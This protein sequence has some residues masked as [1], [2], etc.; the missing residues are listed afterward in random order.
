MRMVLMLCFEWLQSL[1]DTVNIPHLISWIFA[2]GVKFYIYCLPRGV[3]SFIFMT[4][5]SFFSVTSS[6]PTRV[7]FLSEFGILS[8]C[9]SNIIISFYVSYVYIFNKYIMWNAYLILTKNVF[10]E[11]ISLLVRRLYEWLSPAVSH[12]DQRCKLFLRRGVFS[13]LANSMFTRTTPIN[14]R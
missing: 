6:R 10:P 9:Y 5:L 13:F 2:A 3:C 11:Y 1:Y 7:L 4:R 12:H 8:K 14:R